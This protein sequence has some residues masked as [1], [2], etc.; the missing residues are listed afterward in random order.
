MIPYYLLIL[1]IY[2]FALLIAPLAL[3]PDAVLPASVASGLITAG[4]DLGM[5]WSAAPYTFTALIAAIVVV[6]GVETHIFSY[7]SIRW[8]YQKIPGIN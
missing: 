7:K 8:V 4:Q 2:L 3:L 1:L 5:V 6:V